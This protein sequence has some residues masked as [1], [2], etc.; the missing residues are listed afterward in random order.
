MSFLVCKDSKTVEPNF[1]SH[2]DSF[3]KESSLKAVYNMARVS[4]SIYQA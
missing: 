4:E 3:S 2:I 1:P